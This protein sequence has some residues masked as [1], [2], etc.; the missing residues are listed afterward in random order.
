MKLSVPIYRLKRRAKTLSLKE[1]IPLHKALDRIAIKEGFNNW[2]LLAVR[3]SSQPSVRNLL[4]RLSIGDLVLL[5]ARPGHGKTLMGLELISEA[6]NRG[7]QAVLFTLEYNENDVQDRLRSINA[8]FSIFDDQFDFDDSD[9]ISA[10]YIVMKLENA[11]CGTVVVVDYLQL[12]D[13]KRENPAL[14]DQ[15]QT[16]RLLAKKKS[17][18]IVVISQID[19]SF[20]QST[21]SFPELKD[22]RLPNPVDLTL[23]NKT[24]FLNNGEMIISAI[25]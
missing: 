12:L 6:I 7:Q 21:I 14:C 18:I 5:A 1:K 8:K 22:V 11:Q 15:V 13:Q 20:D 25:N 2:S 3:L 17:L 24:C 19:R 4:S 9:N 16:L 23:F 10:D